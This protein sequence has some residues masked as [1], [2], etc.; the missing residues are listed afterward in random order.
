MFSSSLQL[1]LFIEKV[2]ASFTHIVLSLPPLII[3]SVS[4]AT[5]SIS[6]EASQQVGEHIQSSHTSMPCA[7]CAKTGTTE[8]K[9]RLALDDEWEGEVVEEVLDQGILKF[10]VAWVPTLEPAENLSAEMRAA[11]E[12]RKTESGTNR[13]RTL[14]KT[15]P[16]ESGAIRKRSGRSHKVYLYCD[17]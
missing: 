4:S 11:W 10:K 12:K 6:M 9:E 2:E 3:D 14:A 5:M 8:H 13:R 1:K 15:Q 7:K 16:G 17:Y